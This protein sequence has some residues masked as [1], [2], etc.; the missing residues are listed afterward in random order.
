MAYTD[1]FDYDIFISYSHNDDV[2]LPGHQQG[3]VS[4]FGEYLQNWL[5]K[6]RGLQGLKIWK[7]EALAGNTRFDQVIEDRI[8][9]SALFL[10][11]HSHNYQRSEYCRQELAWF[12]KHHHGKT[13]VAGGEEDRLFNILINNIHYS[14]WPSEFSGTSGFPFHDAPSE[15]ASGDPTS[16]NDPRI[17]KQMRALVDAVEV[18][19]NAF[20]KQAAPIPAGADGGMAAEDDGKVRLFFGD[21][22]D[23]LRSFRKRM[24]S[25]LGDEVEI[26]DF[27]PPPYDPQ[28]HNALLDQNLSRASLT[29]HLLD[30]WPGREVDGVDTTFPRLHADKAIDAS[31]PSLIWLPDRLE[32]EDMEDEA[33]ADWLREI[34]MGQ[35]G[36]G[37]FQFIRSSRQAITDQV[38]QTVEELSRAAPATHDVQSFLIDTHQKDQRFA[39]KLAELLSDHNVD[40]EFNK[41][42]R[43]P[44]KSLSDFEEAVREVEN[45]VIMFGQV[46]PGWLKGR[47]Q[48]AVKVVAEQFQMETPLLSNIWVMMLPGSPGQRAIPRTPPLIRLDLL[49]NQSA[50]DIDG[51]LVQ[52]L[53]SAEAE[54]GM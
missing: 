26:L 49:E 15:D 32:E 2:R 35:R 21:V 1:G 6:R 19:L 12:F 17:E 43:D 37:N 51:D 8:A 10:V 39:Y 54:G 28:E 38:R 16:P 40:V 45:L 53:L 20:P 52:R 29:V 31:C 44:I 7:D 4:E 14:K 22:S 41:E 9:K 11:L 25:D 24:V 13:K 23:T 46:A 3:W 30:Q 42:S 50:E 5:E 33:Q 48:T 27:L 34:E 18:T 36:E 47:I